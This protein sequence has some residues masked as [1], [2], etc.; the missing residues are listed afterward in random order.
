MILVDTSVLIHF[1]KGGDSDG[2]RKFRMVLE[3]GIPFGINSLIFQEVLQ[4]AGSEKEYF[5]LKK[6]L[7]TQRFYHLNDPIDSFA[8]AAK[9]Y[10]D[11]KKKGITLRS[12]IDCLIAQT[13]LEHDLF[14]LHDDNDFNSM[15][16]V[17][18]LK[19]FD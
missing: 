13:A 8:R 19:F 18:P 4:G 1:F 11:C 14:L 9:I 5:I 12:T 3:R 2:S 15:S 16:K 17:I 10:F 6:Y 7:E